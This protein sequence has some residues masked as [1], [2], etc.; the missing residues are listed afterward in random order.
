MKG[1]GKGLHGPSSTEKKMLK[2][3]GMPIKGA[4]PNMHE[5]GKEAPLKPIPMGSMHPHGLEPEHI[6]HGHKKL[7]KIP[8]DKLSGGAYKSE[9]EGNEGERE[10][11][12]Y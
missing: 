12:E 11:G 10:K 3:G 4:D 6:K 1:K 5:K 8:A 7:E 9:D 2:P